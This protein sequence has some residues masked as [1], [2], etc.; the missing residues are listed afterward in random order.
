[1]AN[2]EEQEKLFEERL[3]REIEE[4]RYAKWKL[5]KLNHSVTPTKS[6]A[7][8]NIRYGSMVAILGALITIVFSTGL[9][10]ALGLIIC[11]AGLV[12]TYIGIFQEKKRRKEMGI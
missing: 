2:D 10:A 5:E 1:M 7:N 11:F 9:L 8:K 4:A 6:P 3:A 12:P